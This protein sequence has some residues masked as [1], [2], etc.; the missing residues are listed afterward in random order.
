MGGVKP[1]RI[2]D[3][4]ADP[5]DEPDLRSLEKIKTIGDAYMVVAGAP[6]PRPDHAAVI[7]EMA[8]EMQAAA[9]LTEPTP[10]SPPRLRIG[11]ASGPA[12]AGVIGHRKF[13][14]DIWGDTVNL[15]SRMESTGV[16]GAIQAAAS[17]WRLCADRYRSPSERSTSRVWAPC[18]HIS[19]IR[20]RRSEPEMSKP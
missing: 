18:A 17:T 10:G 15:A 9:V 12:V 5:A 6:E 8:L 13:S 19:S 14:Y 7:V 1:A 11:I 2:L 4:G 3:M 20:H 16:P